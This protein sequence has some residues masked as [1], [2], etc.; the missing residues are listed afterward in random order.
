MSEKAEGEKKVEAAPKV[1]LNTTNLLLII[2]IA[3]LLLLIVGGALA[4]V[5][6]YRSSNHAAAA[7]PTAEAAQAENAEDGEKAKG[8]EKKKPEPKE[9][10][11]KGP[12]GPAIYVTLEPPFVVNFAAGK[13]AKFLQISMEIMTRDQGTAQ[14][15]KDNNPLLRNDLLAL[16]GGQDYDAV[17]STDGREMLRTKALDATRAVVKKEGGKGIEVE[18]VYFTS[19]VMQ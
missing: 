13:P 9:V 15:L 18:A 19:L 1:P 12:K 10:K 6:I 14:I 2:V 11:E 8:T 3:V 16:F 5:V 4:T 17:A 7:P